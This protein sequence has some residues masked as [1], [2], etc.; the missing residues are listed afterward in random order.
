MRFR[1][2]GLAVAGAALL[3]LAAASPALADPPP[4][5]GTPP[6][7]NNSCGIGHAVSEGTQEA[8]GIGKSEHELGN[9]NVGNDV[10]QPTHD[11][12][13]DYCHDTSPH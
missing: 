12:V 10:L 8:G 11:V 6:S 9:D 3:A 1:R 5:G 2:I 13:Q 4:S 7:V